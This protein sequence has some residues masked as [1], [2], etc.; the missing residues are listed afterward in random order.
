[1]Q[2]WMHNHQPGGKQ[3][4]SDGQGK[5]PTHGTHHTAPTWTG[6]SE[7]ECLTLEVPLMGPPPSPNSRNGSPCLPTHIPVSRLHRRAVSSRSRACCSLT[8]SSSSSWRFCSRASSWACRPLSMSRNSISAVSF[9]LCKLA[10]VSS[11]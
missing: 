8:S 10:C 6:R 4:P 11:S 9:S 7:H 5:V 1:M 3:G 2:S